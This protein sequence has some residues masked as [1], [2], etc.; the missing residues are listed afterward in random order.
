MKTAVQQASSDPAQAVTV[1][2]SPVQAQVVAILAEGHSITA[3][4]RQASIHR[5]TIYHWLQHS[6]DFKTTVE[7]AQQE[8]LATLSDEMRDLSASALRALR[9]VLDNPETHDAIRLKA[10]LAVLQ[11]P[12]YPN[13]GWHL[14]ERI[15][16]PRQQQMVDTLAE[17]KAEYDMMQMQDALDAGSKSS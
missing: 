15:E 3:A 12:H 5:S 13:P 2:L 8:Y 4:A 6:P 10:A 14:P 17:M 9:G 16:S 11:R 7:D 1:D